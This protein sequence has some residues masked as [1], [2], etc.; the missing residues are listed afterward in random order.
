MPNVISYR[1]N[2]KTKTQHLRLMIFLWLSK[3][4][5]NHQMIAKQQIN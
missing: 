1:E 2:N 3:S 4:L 5:G